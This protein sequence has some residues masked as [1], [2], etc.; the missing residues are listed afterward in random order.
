MKRSRNDAEAN[1]GDRKRPTTEDRRSA[2]ADSFV[3]VPPQWTW[4]LR[5]RKARSAYPDWVVALAKETLQ[6][7]FDA[8]F[9]HERP[10]GQTSG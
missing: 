3:R 4:E 10:R 6:N 9:M 8:W 5:V 2:A 1:E 7:S